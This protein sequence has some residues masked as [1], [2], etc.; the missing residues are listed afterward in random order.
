MAG[1]PS[2]LGWFSEPSIDGVA[3]LAALLSRS[4]TLSLF[5]VVFDSPEFRSIR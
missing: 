4:L 3:F 1:I 5:W 2:L